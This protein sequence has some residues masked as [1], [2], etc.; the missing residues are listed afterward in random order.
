MP[1]WLLDLRIDH[2]GFLFPLYGLTL[3]TATCLLIG[4]RIGARGRL[5]RGAIAIALGAGCGA[6]AALMLAITGL[7]VDP[8][9]CLWC[10]VGGAGLTLAAV[11][12][13][14]AQWWRRV[15]ATAFVPLVLLSFAAGV[16]AE[17][18]AYPYFGE[19]I[20]YMPFPALP[21]A[22]LTRHVGTMDA[23]LG[24]DWRASS[25][26]PGHGIVGA[27][28]IPAV[29]SHFPAREAVVYLPPAALVREPPALPVV[30][31]FPGQPGSPSTVFTSGRVA[32]VFDEYARSHHG[33]APIVV[34]PDQ[35]GFPGH[36]PMCVDSPLGNA[37]TYLTE[38][39]PAWIKAHLPVATDA[40][41]WAVGGYSEGGTCAAQLGAGHPELFSAFVP[42]LSELQPTAGADT[43]NRAFGGSRQR[44]RA[45]TPL[46]LL[47]AHPQ[48]RHDLV[49]FGT[50]ARDHRYT[51]Y[52]KTLASASAAAGI[53]TQLI[54][55]PD[56]GHSWTTVRYVWRRALPA[57][58]DQIGLDDHRSRVDRGGPMATAAAG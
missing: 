47:S 10:S 46:A 33:L 8:V 7:Q 9:V 11:A 21:S 49:I 6:V 54:V 43:V 18:G 25:G 44:Y 48:G 51:S 57:I 39:V 5:A 15:A 16:N 38:D 27:V 2:A 32:Q 52:A 17:Y 41:H 13:R 1:S 12:L 36:N 19:A 42:V 35:L 30:L 50:G 23:R 14:R 20:Q 29:R 34:A 22:L 31:L 24:N 55:A 26:M 56:S 40:S 45:A 37:A 4:L 3:A 53:P 28:D 58:A